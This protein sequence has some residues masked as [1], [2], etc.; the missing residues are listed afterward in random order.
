MLSPPKMSLAACA[1]I[2]LSVFT[3]AAIAE[4]AVSATLD[5][6]VQQAAT[7]VMKAHDI[8]GLAIAVSHDGIQQFYSFGVASKATQAPVTPDTLFEVGSISKLFTAT[9]AAYAQ[10]NGQLSL[11][12]PVEKIPA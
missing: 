9:L 12:D 8:S 5:S 3:R 1:L 4:N 7:E 6:V 2:G 10:A 11:T